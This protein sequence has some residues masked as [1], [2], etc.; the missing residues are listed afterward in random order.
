MTV[1]MGVSIL[2]L[3]TMSRIK[4]QT[5]ISE[6]AQ[7]QKVKDVDCLQMNAKQDTDVLK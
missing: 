3:Y 5:W 4:E 6:Y 7:I 2:F 1:V